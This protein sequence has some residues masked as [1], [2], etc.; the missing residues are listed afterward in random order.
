[1]NRLLA[2]MIGTNYVSVMIHP[3]M[4]RNKMGVACVEHETSNIRGGALCSIKKIH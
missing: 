1:M 4:A 3:M 2:K